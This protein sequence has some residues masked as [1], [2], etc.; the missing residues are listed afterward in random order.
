MDGVNKHHDYISKEDAR[1]PTVATEA[2]LLS[3]IIN[4]EEERDVA[5]IDITSSF[6]QKQVEDEK[7]V[8]F[9]KIRGFLV[10][11]LLQIA[12]DVYKLH[13]AT[14]KNGVKQLMVQSQNALY[15][16][17]VA[18]PLYYRKFTNILTDIGFM[19]YLYDLCIANKIIGGQQMTILYH[20]DDC[21]LSHCRSKVNDRLIKWLKQEYESI[22]ED[23]SGKM[24]ASISKVHNT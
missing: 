18:S 9:I 13:V 1:S 2:V 11:I 19:I 20:V 7:D 16:T 8:A 17:M 5:V 14:D 6:I 15:G 24:M 4:A 21:K 10:D 3:C 12:P 23:G 22:L